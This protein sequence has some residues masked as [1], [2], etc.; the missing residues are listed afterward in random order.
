MEEQVETVFLFPP[1]LFLETSRSYIG[2]NPK[3]RL[4]ALFLALEVKLHNAKHDAMVRYGKGFHPHVL[5][6]RNHLWNTVC[7]IQ[8]AVFSVVMQV[9][10]W[11]RHGELLLISILL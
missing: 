11:A 6:S 2:L 3:N 1:S 10:E 5:G 8:E 7:S 4:D 9:T